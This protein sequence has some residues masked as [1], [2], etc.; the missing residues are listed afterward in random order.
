MKR[1]WKPQNIHPQVVD[2]IEARKVGLEV[3][4]KYENYNYIVVKCSMEGKTGFAIFTESSG[5]KKE[6]WIEFFNMAHFPTKGKRAYSITL[7]YG[8]W[9]HGQTTPEAVYE[10][11]DSKYKLKM[12]I[13]YTG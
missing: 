3:S 8:T 9:Y 11:T 12:K 4:K 10:A 7:T 1:L 13:I 5:W 6:R 2:I